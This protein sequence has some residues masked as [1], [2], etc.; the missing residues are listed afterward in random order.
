MEKTLIRTF[1][2]L[3]L[4]IG[5]FVLVFS[6]EQDEN[7]SNFISH[8]IFDK[9]FGVGCFYLMSKLYSRWSKTDK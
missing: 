9:A 8:V 5:G 6:E 3:T 2:L 4:A 1:I 7:I